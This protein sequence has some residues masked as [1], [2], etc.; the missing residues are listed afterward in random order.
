MFVWGGRG[1]LVVLLQLI[2]F[3]VQL[4]EFD[5]GLVLL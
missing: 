3:K 2:V 5:F 1:L 4:S